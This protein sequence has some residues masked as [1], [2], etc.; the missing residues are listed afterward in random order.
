MKSSVEK[1]IEKK[2]KAEVS[3]LKRKPVLPMLDNTLYKD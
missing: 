1:A 2:N 3:N